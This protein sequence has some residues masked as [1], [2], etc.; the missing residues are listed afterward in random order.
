MGSSELSVVPTGD[1]SA[2]LKIPALAVDVQADGQINEA[3]L[4]LSYLVSIK[5]LTLDFPRPPARLISIQ[6]R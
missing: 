1:S 2:D 3:V 6:L 5:W 4:E